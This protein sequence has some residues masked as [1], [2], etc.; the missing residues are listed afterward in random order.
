MSSLAYEIKEARAQRVSVS[1][2]SLQI[3]LTDGR[4]IIAPL[5]WYPRLWHGSPEERNIYQIIGNGEYIHWSKLD[6]DLTVSGVLAGYCSA[7]SAKSLKKWL[8]GRAQNH[9]STS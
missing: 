1:E 4:T 6:E 3:D 8:D 5:L 9:I 7:E 2:N